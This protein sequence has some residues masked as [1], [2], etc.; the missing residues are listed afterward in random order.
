MTCPTRAVHRRRVDRT[1]PAWPLMT[2]GG[3]R[4]WSGRRD[5][6]VPIIRP[7]VRCSTTGQHETSVGALRL[8]H[9]VDGRLGQDVDV[10]IG[11]L[12]HR[13]GD[14]S[15]TATAELGRDV[16]D[17]DAGHELAVGLPVRHHVATAPAPTTGPT[18]ITARVM[19]WPS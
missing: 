5:H 9:V 10:G 3:L 16:G 4:P 13:D 11:T 19:S 6:R 14:R 15:A 2:T 7:Y 12:G 1:A 18:S 8:R 17:R